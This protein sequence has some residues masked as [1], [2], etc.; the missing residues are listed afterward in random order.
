MLRARL[1]IT[2]VSRF[3]RNPAVDR[4]GKPQDQPAFVNGVI[5]ARTPLPPGD[6]KLG[7]LYAVE[8]ACRRVRTQDRYAPRTLDLDLLAYQD[9]AFRTAVTELPDPCIL[10]HP[11]LAVPLA[12]LAD[13]WVPPGSRD[14]MQAIAQRIGTASLVEEVALTRSVRRLVLGID[15]KG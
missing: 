15:A 4:T 10:V 11:F 7:V 5:R 8:R 3:Y 6:L 13:G 9:L 12:E 14:S 1:C 2:G